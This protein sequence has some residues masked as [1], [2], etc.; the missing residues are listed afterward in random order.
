MNR[1]AALALAALSLFFVL[2][3]LT[4]GKPGLPVGLKSDEPAYYLMAL[5]LAFDRDLRLEVKDVD[6]VFQEFPFRRVENLI[7]ATDD[8]WRTVHFGK[9]YVYSLFA[10]P[11]ARWFGA[12]GLVSFNLALL[13]GLVWLGTVYLGR[14]NPPGLAALF[15]AGFVLL[16]NG[17]AYAFWL[18]PEV[19]NM[20]AVGACLFLGFHRWGAAGRDPG[21]WL[22]GLSGGALALA[23]YN[24][25]M[26]AAV[27]LALLLGWARRR[28]W[29]EAGAWLAGAALSLAALAGLSVALTG[30]PTSYL[31]VRRQ[32]VAVCEPGRMPI[33]PESTAGGGSAPKP[34]QGTGG[35]WSWIFHLPRVPPGELL[36]SLGYFLWGRHAGLLL[37]APFAGLCLLL[38]LFHER[39]SVER[40][41]LLGTL[42]AIALFFV[43]FI[44]DNWQGGGGFIGNRYYVSA[45]PAFLFLVTRLAPQGLV[46]VGYALGGIFLGPILFTPF[47][48]AGPEPTLQAHVRNPPFRFFPLELSLREIP[49]YIEQEVG[50]VQFLGRRDVVL[51]QGEV[52]WLRGASRVELWL[53][54][55]R[56]IERAV[57]A[58]RNLAPGNRLRLTLPGAAA[59]LEFGDVGGQGE[60]RRL[61]LR[62]TGPTQVRR[63]RGTPVYVYRL[64][65]WPATGRIRH[66][67]RWMPPDPCPYF[68]YN[69]SFEES[70]L[71]GAEL[72]FLGDGRELERDVFGLRWGPIELPAQVEAGSEFAATVRLVNRSRED[73]SAAGAARVRLA[74]HWRRPDGEVLVWDGRRTELP[75]PVA[76]GGRAAVEQVFEAPAEP[77]RYVLEIE[78]VFE[79]VA[80]FSDR[81][82]ESVYRATVE[83]LP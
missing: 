23:V 41:V 48:P 81:H 61:E 63:I 74:Y 43:A 7:L 68:A 1:P 77:G 19:F 54:S 49:G 12:N 21:P 31:G 29:R 16:S 30:H 42:A 44:P 80:W 32:G 82:P 5:S 20:A 59:E 15:A 33:A 66:W 45:Y 53:S 73:W 72:L 47:G 62:P 79:Y 34:V 71:V 58:L 60:S 78:P 75:L 9:P 37:Y 14:F 64:V 26:L 55:P 2:F 46:A 39:R 10:A 24:K 17:F 6:R 56:P 70:F 35:A 8:G 69:P 50:P 18:H 51:P 83:V 3:P 40:W 13:M 25:P 36:R 22:A 67:T 76:A 11:W 57:F 38:F 27:G 4:L 65:V 52:L 28:C